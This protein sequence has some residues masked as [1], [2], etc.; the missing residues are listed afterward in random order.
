M[1]KPACPRSP[2]VPVAGACPH[3]EGFAAF[4]GVDVALDSTQRQTPTATL[5][6]AGLAQ[7]CTPGSQCSWFSS[8]GA[9]APLWLSYVAA[10]RTVSF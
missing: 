10:E 4:W 6:V 1:R 8:D 5:D 2:N 9:Q 7:R 3:V